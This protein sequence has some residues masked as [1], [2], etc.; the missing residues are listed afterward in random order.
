MAQ[1][2]HQIRFDTSVTE[3]EPG[4]PARLFVWVRR[5]Q[6]DEELTGRYEIFDNLAKFDEFIARHEAA[7]EDITA[8][9]TARDTFADTLQRQT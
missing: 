3:P 2:G 9:R 6:G 1:G 7:G 8:L 4:R 5:F